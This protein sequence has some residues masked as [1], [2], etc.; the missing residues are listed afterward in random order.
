MPTASL[1]SFYYHVKP[2]IP[3]QI[4]IAMRRAIVRR[5]R[6]KCTEKW[7]ILKRAAG[8]PEGWTGWP[9]GKRF[10]L[11]LTHD[12]DTARGLLR[13]GL[14]ADLE[15]ALGF[16]SSFNFVAEDYGVTALQ[17]GFLRD[18]GFEIGVHGIKHN[19]NPFRSRKTMQGQ[20]P[21]INRYLSEWGAVGF[22]CPSMFHDLDGI[23]NLDVL[24]DSSTFD[25]DPFEPQPDGIETIFPVW[26]SAHAPR[27]GYVELPYTLPQDFTLFVLMQET[28][29]SIWKKKLDWIAESGGMA[30]VNSHP[31]YMSFGEGA[32][33]PDEFNH[34]LYADFLRYVQSTYKNEY[35]H[36]LPKDVAFFWA[37]YQR[38]VSYLISDISLCVGTRD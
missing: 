1:V 37:A 22:R 8:P 9:K 23:A 11:V 24:Y 19:G 2:L 15:E 5:K 7:P 28:D 3:R 38:D 16:R 27:P 20:V 35:W 14:L 36:A 33:R 32:L 26:I 31:D 29:T 4:Q 21:K 12:V 30:L 17:R 13:C 25:T 18:R 10:A 34:C 6:K